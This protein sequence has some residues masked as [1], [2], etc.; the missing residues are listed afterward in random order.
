MPPPL[1]EW[2][3]SALEEFGYEVVEASSAVEAM[4]VLESGRPLRL[5]FT[6]L[7][8]PGG[9]DGRKLAERAAR[10]RPGM[11]S[12]LTTAYAGD[13]LVEDGR[14]APGLQLLPKPYTRDQLKTALATLADQGAPDLLLV[15]DDPAVRQTLADCL[16]ELG[17]VVEEAAT[18]SRAMARIG[19]RR[20]PI[21]AAIIDLEL[22]DGSGLALLEALR[23]SHRDALA[24]VA[25]GYIG[26]KALQRITADAQAVILPKPF[27][28]EDLHRLLVELGLL[29]P[30][31][32]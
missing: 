13:R 24:I 16:R 21:S 5:M 23:G 31:A 3:R 14:L 30:P 11:R 4:Q 27:S 7:S 8:L 32:R 9:L 26:E 25:S 19:D 2:A 18:A 29:E 15:E 12:L 6:D 22:P 28:G 17:C 10:V 1:R 20:R